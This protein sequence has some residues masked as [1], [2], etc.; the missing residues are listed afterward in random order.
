ML[1]SELLRAIENQTTAL[2]VGPEL[3]ALRVELQRRY[4]SSLT[5]ILFYGSCL[6]SGDVLLQLAI[7]AGFIDLSDADDR[8]VQAGRAQ[9]VFHQRPAG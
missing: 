2:E 8:R 3:S 6:R 1:P 4:G 5:A 9:R 7:A